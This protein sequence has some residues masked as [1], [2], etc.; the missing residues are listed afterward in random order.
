MTKLIEF[1]NQ[2]KEVLRGL[3]DEAKSDLGVIFVHGFERTTVESKFKNIAD[4][5]REKVNTFRFDFSGCGLS[6][7]KFEDLT[8]DK[9]TQE[10]NLAVS[11]LKSACPKIKKI[12][13]VAHSFGACVALKFVANNASL[14]G[15]LVFLGP[16]FNQK[17]LLRYWFAGAQAK[18]EKAEISWQNFRNYF[19]EEKFQAD[20][21]IK[22]RLTKEHK[23]FNDYFIENSTADFQ[24][25]FPKVKDRKILII[26]GDKDDKVSLESNDKLFFGIEIIKVVGGDHDLQ[27]LNMVEQYLGKAVIFLSEN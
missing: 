22:E 11:A 5:F 7:G 4:A 14:S 13:F 18:K 12:N 15:N 6:D 26:H 9:L 10:L 1:K 25:E 2:N 19:S 21:K 23:L 20:L 8:T 24:E 16:A 3:L 27:K 17:E